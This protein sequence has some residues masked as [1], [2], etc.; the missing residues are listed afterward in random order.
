MLAAN[1]RNCSLMRVFFSFSVKR[2]FLISKISATT[3]M[4]ACL[5]MSERNKIFPLKTSFHKTSRLPHP[6]AIITA[7]ERINNF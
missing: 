3:G 2:F 1:C 5:L 4:L 6:K 7:I